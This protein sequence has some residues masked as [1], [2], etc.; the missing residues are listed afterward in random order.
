MKIAMVIS[1]NPQCG[2]TTHAEYVISEINKFKDKK[3]TVDLVKVPLNILEKGSLRKQYKL[4]KEL[5]KKL[6][7]EYDLI[8]VQHEYGLWGRKIFYYHY[9]LYTFT[10]NVDKPV[11]VSWHS[12][13]PELISPKH[14]LDSGGHTIIRNSKLFKKIKYKVYNKFLNIIY[15]NISC[16]ILHSKFSYDLFYNSGGEGSAVTIPLGIPVRETFSLEEKLKVKKQKKLENKRV[17]VLFGFVSP[18]KGHMDAI[19]ALKYLDENTILVIAGGA[20]PKNKD[21]KEYEW[22]LLRQAHNLQVR[23]RVLITGFLQ[24]DEVDEWQ[25]AADL[26]LAPYTDNGLSASGA[27]SRAFTMSNIVV[28]SDIDAFIG[29]AEQ[30]ESVKI[31]PRNNVHKLV[32]IINS[33]FRETDENI[34]NLRKKSAQFAQAN[35][36]A[37]VALEHIKLYKEAIKNNRK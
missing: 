23:D 35:S 24:E 27:I 32:K 29:L 5:A 4:F 37:V 19:N 33:I 13:V 25:K 28:G 9:N 15:K 7:E 14:I 12:V 31:F 8:H 17:L 11:I 18:Y 26:V 21:G 16:N 3:T 30:T 34:E 10:R 20:H 22:E 6:N 1:D 36:M 2:I